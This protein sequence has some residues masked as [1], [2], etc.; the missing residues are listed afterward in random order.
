[1]LSG[2]TL[3]GPF[4]RLSRSLITAIALLF[5]GMLLALG[6]GFTGT[7]SA[8]AMTNKS[9]SSYAVHLL[10]YLNKARAQHGLRPLAW[11]PGT[12][13]VAEAWTTRM[14]K[15]RYL[16][17]NPALQRQIERHGSYN[18]RAYGENVGV[19]PKK[20]GAWVLFRAYMHS[21]EHRAN[22]LDG[23]YRYVGIG[24]ID[25]GRWAYNTLDF[26]DSYR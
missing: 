19:S 8:S 25:R 7:S 6:P 23:K 18:W 1:M 14:A 13:R 15:G 2:D 21:P 22:I 10:Q 16:A 9:S 26:V 24:V 17:H 5:A 4:I 20:K 11:A 12:S 3:R